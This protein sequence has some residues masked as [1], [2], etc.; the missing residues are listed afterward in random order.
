M[1]YLFLFTDPIPLADERMKRPV[2]SRGEPAAPRPAADDAA[3]GE[4]MLL[5]ILGRRGSSEGEW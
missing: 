1:P 2:T 5:P 4:S 3:L